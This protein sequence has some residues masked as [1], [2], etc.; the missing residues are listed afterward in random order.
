MTGHSPDGKAVFASDEEVDAVT[1]AL[2]PGYE[3]HRLWGGDDASRFPDAGT[4][5]A[6]EQYFPPVGGFR[7]GLFTLPPASTAGP[8]EVDMAA[9][10]A[11]FEAALPGMASHMEPDAPGMHTT[12]T[13]DYEFVVSGRVVLELDD[14]ASVELGPGDTVVQNGTRHRWRNAGTEPA[15]LFVALLGAKTESLP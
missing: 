11:E 9:A 8:G 15:V 4:Q 12:A 6:H 14:G 2:L 1:V 10:L 5:P 7:F 13:V 3:F